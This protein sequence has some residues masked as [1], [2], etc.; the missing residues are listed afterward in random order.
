M[1]YTAIVVR[2]ASQ[3]YSRQS[4]TKAWL[5]KAPSTAVKMY[6][7]GR[8]VFVGRPKISGKWLCSTILPTSLVNLPCLLEKHGVDDHTT[9]YTCLLS[10]IAYRKLVFA[11]T[12]FYVKT[13]LAAG[14]RRIP[15]K[16]RLIHE[17]RLGAHSVVP[18]PNGDIPSEWPLTQ[19]LETLGEKLAFLHGGLCSFLFPTE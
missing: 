6:V 15:H 5:L 2:C 7:Q 17:T 4:S 10:Q 18:I 1:L 8:D 11:V 16:I 13:F 9:L 3:I 19:G 12:S 14:N